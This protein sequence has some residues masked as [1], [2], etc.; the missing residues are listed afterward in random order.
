MLLEIPVQWLLLEAS[1]GLAHTQ[2]GAAPTAKCLFCNHN[3]TTDQTCHELSIC[4]I[5]RAS[6][7]LNSNS[8]WRTTAP[9]NPWASVLWSFPVS[10]DVLNVHT[11]RPIFSGYFS[12]PGCWY[13]GKY[14]LIL[15]V[16]PSLRLPK[17]CR[18]HH[19]LIENRD[20]YLNLVPVWRLINAFLIYFLAFDIVKIS[21][22]PNGFQKAPL[23]LAKAGIYPPLSRVIFLFFKASHVYF[24]PSLPHFF[25]L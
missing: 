12:A 25:H 13:F 5:Y 9:H 23:G 2:R 8:S 19:F 24:L 3:D 1:L 4:Y 11:R 21:Y 7:W 22:V 15:N 18:M 17:D 6:L 14:V 16:G 20:I 10:R